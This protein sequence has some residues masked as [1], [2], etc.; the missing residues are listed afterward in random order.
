MFLAMNKTINAMQLI[1]KAMGENYFALWL[2]ET[3]KS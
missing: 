2:N 1:I 3:A